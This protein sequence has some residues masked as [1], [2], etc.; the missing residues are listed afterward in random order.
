V[1]TQVGG[2]VG[3]D[4]GGRVPRPRAASGQNGLVAKRP[5]HSDP[6]EHDGDGG[7][8]ADRRHQATLVG[9][10]VAVVLLAWFALANLNRVR[11]DFWVFH[12]DAP[13]IVVIVISGLLGALITALIMRRK[14]KDTPKE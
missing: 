11:I 5:V 1:C 6:L 13:L 12:R 7:K 8:P 4:G 9:V 14:P 2:G 3:D 10:A